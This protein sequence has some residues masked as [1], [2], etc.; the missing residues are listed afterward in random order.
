MPVAR[1]VVVQLRDREDECWCFGSLAAIFERFSREELGTTYSSLS[2][3]FG[4]GKDVYKNGKCI[5]MRVPVI[6]K[7]RKAN[8]R[9]D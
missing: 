8:P 7:R 3:R 5:V 4:K 2:S 6:A 1:V 9:R